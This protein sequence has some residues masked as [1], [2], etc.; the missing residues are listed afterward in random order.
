MKKII[1]LLLA[2]V[3]TLSLAACAGSSEPT[4]E[5]TDATETT[6]VTEAT[7]ATEESTEAAPTSLETTIPQ[8][9]MMTYEEYIAAEL[10]TEV[11]IETVVQAK[12]SWWDNKATL[13]TQDENGAYFIYDMP[14]TEADYADLAV[15]TQIRVKG[16]KGEWAGEVEIMEAQF[17]IIGTPESGSITVADLSE[18]LGTEE[19]IDYQN[20]KALFRNATV[21]ASTN[22]AG[23]EVPFM[24]GW[25]GSGEAGTDADLYFNLEINGVTQ[26]F[27]VEYYTCDDFGNYGDQTAVYQAVQNL[28]IGDTI[29][30]IYCFMYWY[31]GAQPHVVEIW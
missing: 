26:T 1:A 21:V 18:K 4:S 31:E 24:Y 19:L 8:D 2:L 15:G 13:Y 14:C 9:G 28:Q 22:A 5:P 7:D 10:D 25:D 11:V 17:E 27:V 3:I 29:D 6:D 30:T 12:Q 23:E 16:Y 20:F